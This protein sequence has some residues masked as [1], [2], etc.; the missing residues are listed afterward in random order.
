MTDIGTTPRKPL[1]PAQRL[2]VFEERGGICCVCDR[3]IMA[4]EP[5][6]DEHGRAL[7][8]GGSN[9]ASNRFVAHVA[10]AAIKTNGPD[11]D[12]ARIA[13]AKRIKRKHLGIRDP[14]RKR[15]QSRGFEPAPP[16]RTASR[17]LERSR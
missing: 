17:P 7:G 6:I 15:I 9:A 11:G 10:C 1:T 16:Q 4:G 3:K 12:L 8:L 2:R 13:K 14:R 5:W